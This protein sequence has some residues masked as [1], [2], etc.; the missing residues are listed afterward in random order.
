MI[1]IRTNEKE[2]IKK[3]WTNRYRVSFDG[4]VSLSGIS[5]LGYDRLKTKAGN[6]NY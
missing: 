1:Y 6:E 2:T 5:W 4:L 3:I